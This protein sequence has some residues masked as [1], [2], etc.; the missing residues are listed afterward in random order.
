[1]KY[2]TELSTAT[3]GEN[4]LAL[5]AGWLQVFSV[6]SL[7]REYVS[8]SMEY[9]PVGVSLPA[10]CYIDKPEQPG[11]GFAIV[12]SA[13]DLSWETVEDNRGLT[14]YSTATREAHT[15]TE[16]GAIADGVT[17]LVPGLYDAWDGGKWVTDE[18]AQRQA[19]VESARLE[20]NRRMSA[21]SSVIAT[22]QYAIDT[23][24]ATDEET[25]RL[26]QWKK[27]S[28]L[29]SRIDVSAAPDITWPVAPDAGA[30]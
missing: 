6:E 12:R 23:D 21:A 3:L 15:V 14:V 4:G 26:E 30:Q 27:Y 7:N 2:N 13:D 17:P 5:T 19:E 28:V 9:L 24:M 18:E 11:E 29:L 20:L 8:T 10:L 1:M 16:L 22:L 25:Q